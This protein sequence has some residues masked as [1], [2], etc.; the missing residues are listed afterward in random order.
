[1]NR[2]QFFTT[3]AS[4]FV[5]PLIVKKD[6]NPSPIYLPGDFIHD[7]YY[8]KYLKPGVSINV[9]G[10]RDGFYDIMLQAIR[11]G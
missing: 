9:Y 10:D 11:E 6:K 7:R 2:R 5:I 1:M 4:L 3:V 8:P